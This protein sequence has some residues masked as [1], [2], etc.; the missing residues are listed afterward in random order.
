MVFSIALTIVGIVFVTPSS[1]SEAPL[2]LTRSIKFQ[3]APQRLASA[4]L[5]FSTQAGV[6]ISTLGREVGDVQSPGISGVLPI[7]AALKQLLVGTGFGYRLAG[8]DG[9]VVALEKIGARTS[10]PPFHDANDQTTGPLTAGASSAPKSEDNR[11]TQVDSGSESTNTVHRPP[12]TLEEVIVTARKREENAQ[13]VPLSL[14]VLDSGALAKMG[15]TDITTIKD[16]VPAID[17][18]P[19]N[20]SP[21]EMVVFMRG[22]GGT[23]DEQL[24]RDNGVGVYLDDVYVGHGMMLASQLAD[25][26]RIEVLPGPQGTLYGRNT[27]GGAVKF[28]SSKPTGVF[29]VKNSMDVGNFG[30]VDN[31][32]SFDLPSVEQ[33]SAKLTALYS[34]DDG[35]V[36]NDGSAGNFGRRDATGFRGALRWDPTDDLTV[37]YVYDHSDTH[38]TPNYLQYQYNLNLYGF[39]IIPVSPNRLETSWR[40]E[41]FPQDDRFIGSGDA[42]TVNWSLSH[43]VSVKSITAY[44]E[45][46]ASYRADSME[47]FDLGI[48]QAISTKQHQF[49]QEFLLTGNT[50]DSGLSYHLGLFYFKES[51]I[52]YFYQ[53]NDF[54]QLS[55]AVPYIPP[56]FADMD[57]NCI[58]TTSNSS[59]AVYGDLVWAPPI[60][61]RRLS[62]EVG[63]RESSDTREITRHRPNSAPPLPVD[64]SGEASYSSFDPAVT[65]DYKMTPTAH[66]YAKVSK[67]YQAGGFDAFNND[68]AHAFGPEHVTNYEVGVKSEWLQH[69][70]LLNADAFYEQYVH[71]QEIF[72]DP[73]Y[74]STGASLT[75]NAGKARIGGGE[76]Q[77]AVLPVE[78]LSLNAQVV[79]LNTKQTVT[80]PFL[81]VTTTGPLSSAPMWKG[82]I[83]AEY[84]FG[85]FY[86][87]Q[88]SANVGYSLNAKQLPIG[89]TGIVGDYRPAY[90]LLDARL[91]LSDIK[92]SDGNLAV[93][94]WGKNLTDA[95]YETYHAFQGVEYGQ[96]RTYG[97]NVTYKFQ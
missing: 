90:W 48:A 14:T 21:L 76:A 42:L 9:I 67:A 31:V 15:F 37:D 20:N 70:L 91:T 10:E 38:G 24:S 71:M 55:A 80:D 78:A 13:D 95:Q 81:F 89:E 17:I 87:G 56:T 86:F 29:D 72:F 49:S 22:V 57:L 2:D 8:T 35:W 58:C 94:V 93:S 46:D 34:H 77:I 96:P 66:M 69:R 64:D 25:I 45:V 44:R 28:I 12:G 88:V 11:S 23:D 47:G 92:M 54:A 41:N 7:G 6:Q 32:T 39:N 60:L 53:N 40:P 61:D 26:E 59:K 65:I 82:N 36:K 68:Y 73:N 19:D 52:Q 62:L 63:G 84:T 74:A 16:R 51:G 33:V 43:Q 5:Q 50:I 27:I 85:R 79:Y 18:T 1:A 30:Y 83:F 75:V 4:L 97:L 3:I